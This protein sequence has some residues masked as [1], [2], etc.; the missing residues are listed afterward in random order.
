MKIRPFSQGIFY[1]CIASLFWGF[2]QPLFFNEIK[3]IPAI[4]IA[5][6]RGLWSFLF[7]LIIIIYLGKIKDFIFIFKSYKKI[8]I[9]SF[10]S[11]LITIN[12]TGFIFAVS[13]NR[14]QDAS[15]GYFITPMISIALGYFFLKEKISRLQLISILMMLVSIIFLIINLKTF[16]FIA[17]LIGTSWSIYGFLRKQIDVSAEIGLLYESG[18]ITL[19]AVP[20]LIFLNYQNSGF[21]LNH[22]S[23][24]SIY[25]I[26]TGI[27]TIFP[28]FFF[29]L[30]VKFIPLGLAGV[31]FYLAPTFHFITSIFILNENMNLIKLIAFIIIWIGVAVFIIDVLKD[32]KKINENKTQSLN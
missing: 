11:I 13:I 4:E 5:T 19:V 1:T 14:V 20:Y 25:L 6:H 32:E 17:I 28:L 9:L 18:I 26:L 3:F 2:P 27:V 23:I 10:T 31:I 21:F 30:G 15:M 7:L 24:T 8:L 22:S 16:P 12:W 29:N